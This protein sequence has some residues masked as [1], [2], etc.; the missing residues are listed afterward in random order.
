MNEVAEEMKKNTLI[1]NLSRSRG[2]TKFTH[3]LK[4][5]HKLIYGNLLLFDRICMLTLREMLDMMVYSKF[6]SQGIDMMEVSD[7]KDLLMLWFGSEK[8]KK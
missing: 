2:I 4:K 6:F 7:L 1:K 5:F 3:N 8:K